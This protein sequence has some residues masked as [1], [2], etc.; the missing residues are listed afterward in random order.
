MKAVCEMLWKRQSS[1]AAASRSDFLC[2]IKGLPPVDTSGNT[3]THF[4]TH[5]SSCIHPSTNTGTCLGFGI[6]ILIWS[7]TA[8]HLKFFVLLWEC[9]SEPSICK[10]SVI[11]LWDYTCLTVWWI[12]LQQAKIHRPTG[13]GDV[14][15]VLARGLNMEE[16]RAELNRSIIWICHLSQISDLTSWYIRPV[17][18]IRI[19]SVCTWKMRSVSMLTACLKDTFL[20]VS[21]VRSHLSHF[22]PYSNS[23]TESLHELKSEV[24]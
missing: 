4:R 10:M 22:P 11:A 8:L 21:T 24:L 13:A 14:S 12:N 9:G 17:P 20:K 23:L 1:W 7:D 2:I 15:V 3:A 16:H 18:R 6:L 5:Q 19:P